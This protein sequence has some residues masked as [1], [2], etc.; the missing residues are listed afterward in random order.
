MRW[1]LPRA[2]TCRTRRPRPLLPPR[3]VARGLP[4]SPGRSPPRRRPLRLRTRWRQRQPAVRTILLV[5]DEEDVRRVLGGLF[6]LVG[7]DVIEA[8]DPVS[9]AKQARSWPRP[10]PRSS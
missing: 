2:S 3:A 10:R 7:Y 5:D 1:R 4:A 9:A 6:N 8:I